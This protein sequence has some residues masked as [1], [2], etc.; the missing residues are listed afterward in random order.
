MKKHLMLIGGKWVEPASGAWLESVNP[1]TATPWALVPRGGREDVDRAV[2]AA[3]SA[4][5]DGEWRKLTAT[6][7]GA[8]LRCFAD[9][10]ASEADA[11]AK[12]ET[13]DNGK[14]IA[15]MGGQLDRKSV[16]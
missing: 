2:A 16:V 5:Y 11:L 3:K 15:E 7:R 14:L 4:F 8:L 6:A 12:I 10:I 9:I 1:F 13:T